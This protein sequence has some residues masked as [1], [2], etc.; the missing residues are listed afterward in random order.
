[1]GYK[2]LSRAMLHKRV[3][4]SELCFYIDSCLQSMLKVSI[5]KRWPTTLEHPHQFTDQLVP[6]HYMYQA[7]HRQDPGLRRYHGGMSVANIELLHLHQQVRALSRG[8]IRG[9]K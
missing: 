1:M 2:S 4:R 5:E 9:G 7:C 3:Y 6:R 8:C